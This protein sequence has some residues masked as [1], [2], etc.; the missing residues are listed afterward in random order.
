MPVLKPED[1]A[2]IK[3][4]LAF[5]RND[6]VFSD[7]Y[8]NLFSSDDVLDLI[9]RVRKSYTYENMNCAYDLSK[10]NVLDLFN[11]KD[12]IIDILTSIPYYDSE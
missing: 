4:I 3:E 9:H 5:T 7:Y 11:I 1:I 12:D 6:I 10:W 8:G 2:L